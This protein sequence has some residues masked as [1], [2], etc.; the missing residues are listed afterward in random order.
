[1]PQLFDVLI[2]GALAFIMFGLGTELTAL[3]FMR[4]AQMPKPVLVGLFGHTIILPLAAF[5]MIWLFDVPTAFALGLM[6]VA[7]SPGGA[8]SNLWTYLARGD[9]A[10]A[11]T[12]TAL[13]AGVAVFWVPVMLNITLAYFVGESANIRMP[14]G[15]T[16]VHIAVLTVIPVGAGMALRR[17]APA[18][19]QRMHGTVKALSVLFLGLAVVGILVRGRHELPTM[20]LTAGLPVLAYN[21]V[22]MAAGLAL[23][24]AFRLTARQV[25]TI[26]MEIGIQNVIMAATLATAPQFLGRPDAGLVPSVYG[27]TMCVMALGFIALTRLAPGVLG[28]GGRAALAAQPSA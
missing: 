15:D 16:M 21:F 14:I 4:L 11:V 9:V 22:V 18:F 28:P 3:D 27:F 2:P 23:A 7:A 17:F 25:I 13:S 20:L 10:L 19:A 8:V 26:P 24:R 6:V 5:A 1:M 12:L